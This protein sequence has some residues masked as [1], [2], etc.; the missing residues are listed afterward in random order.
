MDVDFV[1]FHPVYKNMENWDSQITYT[2]DVF[3]YHFIS[4]ADCEEYTCE[5]N[6]CIADDQVCDGVNDC[7]DFSD[8]TD[9]RE[10][11]PLIPSVG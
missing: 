5:N 10:Y 1:N 7:I 8:E 11:I 6:I 4:N 3:F 2:E 9:C